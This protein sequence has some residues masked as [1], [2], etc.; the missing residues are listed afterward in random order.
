[1]QWE[2][3]K[4]ESSLKVYRDLKSII[5]TAFDDGKEEGKI[6]GKI[7]IAKQAKTMG[8][9]IPNIIKLTG[10]SKKEINEL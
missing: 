6:Q 1:G 8:L 5:D 2:L 3:D 9:S 10:L 4:Y 7:E